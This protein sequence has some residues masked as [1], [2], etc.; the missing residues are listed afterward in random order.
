MV[1]MDDKTVSFTLNGQGAEIGMGVAY[2]GEG[3]RPCG[4]VYACVSF[5]RKEKLKIILGGAYSEDFRFPPPQEY[6]GVGEAVTAAIEECAYITAKEA[7]LDHTT[8]DGKNVPRYL[9]DFSDSEHGH[10]LMA[11]AHRYYGSDASVHLGLGRSKQTSQR[12]SSGM[13]SDSM[14]SACLLRR[15]ETVVGQSLQTEVVCASDDDSDVC[16]KVLSFVKFAYSK[17]HLAVCSELV[18]EVI[19]M[20][21]L[22]SRKLIL[23]TLITMGREFEPKIFLGDVDSLVS[24]RKLW[25]ALEACMS[26]R[27]A[28]WVGE[29]G[30]M[31]L[32]A[33]ALG[34]GI[35]SADHLQFRMP[36]DRRGSVSLSGDGP[37]LPVGG[38]FQLLTTLLHP[39]HLESFVGSPHLVSASTESSLCGNGGS[40]IMGFLRDGLQK[41]VLH[42]K[43]FRELGD[44]SE[45]LR[46][47]NTTI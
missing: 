16:E 4:G 34:L 31:A 44:P 8:D 5:N 15:F 29:A 18:F 27:H 7:V 11:W 25:F 46:P 14:V 26:L 6:R 3:F 36:A 10:E 42:S 37:V 13:S 32:A 41:A 9:C 17:V 1:D 2:S 35:S 12:L 28:G 23:H 39:F 22:L 40:G 43:S 47:L 21:I 20:S 24:A 33:E 30:A 19:A 45:F 38:G